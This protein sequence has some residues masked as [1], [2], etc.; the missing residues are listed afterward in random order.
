MFK[1]STISTQYQH[2]SKT[3]SSTIQF[4][5]RILFLNKKYL[6]KFFFDNIFLSV[7]CCTRMPIWRLN[8]G[9]LHNKLQCKKNYPLLQ[10]PKIN[11]EYESTHAWQLL[12][13]SIYILL[14]PREMR[15]HNN[16]LSITPQKKKIKAPRQ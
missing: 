12:S 1:T 6:L 16:K 7:K 8:V 2:Q 9:A 3:I 10:K 4:K 13:M 15:N 11:Y 14:T 5:L